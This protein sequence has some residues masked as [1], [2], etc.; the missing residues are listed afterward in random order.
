MF[1]GYVFDD[2]EHIKP[3][4]EK[5]DGPTFRWCSAQAQRLHCYV[6]AGFPE[7]RVDASG[8][9]RYLNSAH[10]V[11]RDGK[12]IATYSKHFLYE[13]VGSSPARHSQNLVL[14]DERQDKRWA[15]EGPNFAAFEL[16]DLGLKVR[17]LLHTVGDLAV[18][19]QYLHV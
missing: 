10:V 8:E 5:Q 12:S 13:T 7:V 14:T 4:L 6:I 19:W 3:F 2:L 18:C 15:E 11:G 17:T 1:S 9:E 16:P